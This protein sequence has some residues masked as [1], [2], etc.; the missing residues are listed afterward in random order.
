MIRALKA[1]IAAKKAELA[2]LQGALGNA[3]AMLLKTVREQGL[4]AQQM[5]EVAR[6]S[7]R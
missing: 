4:S 2:A 5:Q 3:S 7:T 1:Q 6:L